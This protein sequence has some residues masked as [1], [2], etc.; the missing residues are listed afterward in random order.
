M[1]PQYIKH[2]NEQ[3]T[4]K[5]EKQTNKPRISGAALGYCG[6][7]F[8]IFEAEA[9]AGFCFLGRVAEEA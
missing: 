1:R 7:Y 2:H 8:K 6:I 5:K 3:R 4:N 9:E